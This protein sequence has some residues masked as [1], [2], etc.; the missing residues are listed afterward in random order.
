MQ[1]FRVNHFNVFASHLQ[2]LLINYLKLQS[3]KADTIFNGALGVL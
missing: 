3:I 1:A 2:N